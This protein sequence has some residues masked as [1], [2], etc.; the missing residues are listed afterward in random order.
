LRAIK[1]T[2]AGYASYNSNIKSTIVPIAIELTEKGY[3]ELQLSENHLETL[4]G[5]IVISFYPIFSKGNGASVCP[6]CK[7]EK[8]IWFSSS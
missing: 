8:E 7:P 3:K 6:N 1:V 4:K 5:G 2:L